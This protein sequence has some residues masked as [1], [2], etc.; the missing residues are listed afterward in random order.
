MEKLSPRD[1]LFEV[2]GDKFRKGERRRKEL[3]GPL[4]SS[5]I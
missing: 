4:C 1:R 5:Y 3:L 2:A